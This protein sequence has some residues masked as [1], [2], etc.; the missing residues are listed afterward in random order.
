MW[1]LLAAFAEGYHESRQQDLA[2]ELMATELVAARTVID[3]MT[4]KFKLFAAFL[5]RILTEE[6]M[7]EVE[8]WFD[9]L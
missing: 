6:Q 8:R 5:N 3:D 2:A 9:E 4:A 1:E 7:I